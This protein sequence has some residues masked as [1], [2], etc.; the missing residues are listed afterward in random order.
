MTKQASHDP[1]YDPYDEMTDE[2][3]D[4]YVADLFARQRAQSVAVSMR[5]PQDLLARVK[6]VA[7]ASDV[8]Y[9]TLIKN[10]VAAALP[11]VEKR[12]AAPRKM[13]T[14]RRK[15]TVERG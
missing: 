11:A 7:D 12:Q 2:E 13:A 8:P 9:Q 4:D 6:R 10:L 5:W 3:L 15:T 1:F 14:A